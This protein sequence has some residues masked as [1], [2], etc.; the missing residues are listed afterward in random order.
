MNSRLGHKRQTLNGNE[1]A[2]PAKPDTT[3]RN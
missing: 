3:E 2:R 1:G